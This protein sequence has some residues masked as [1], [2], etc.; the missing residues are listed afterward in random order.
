M[1]TAF[2]GKIFRSIQE[3][4]EKNKEDIEEIKYTKELLNLM[5]IRVVGEVADAADLP[6]PATYDGDFGDGFAVGT[7]T[8]YDYYIYTRAFDDNETPEWFNIGPFPI[9]G[10]EGPQGPRGPQGIQGPRGPQGFVGPRGVQGPQGEQGEQ[11]EEGP[12][13]PQGIAGTVV[14]IAG[15]IASTSLL[16]AFS[17]VNDFHLGYLVGTVVPYHLYVITGNPNDKDTW[18]WFDAGAFTSGGEY[19]RAVDENNSYLASLLVNTNGIGGN[20]NGVVCYQG[21]NGGIYADTYHAVTGV[22]VGSND[23]F[24]IGDDGYIYGSYLN[25]DYITDANNGDYYFDI[26]NG[27]VYAATIETEQIADYNANNVNP[28]GYPKYYYVGFAA[29]GSMSANQTVCLQIEIRLKNVNSLSYNQVLTLFNSISETSNDSVYQGF[30]YLLDSIGA[31]QDLTDI[32][33][34]CV[35]TICFVDTTPGA[36]ASFTSPAININHVYQSS[37]FIIKKVD[38]T[39]YGNTSWENFNG[40]NNGIE[41]YHDEWHN[42]SQVSLTYCRCTLDFSNDNGTDINESYLANTFFVRTSDDVEFG[43]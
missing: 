43:A 6:D 21:G 27:E 40:T 24:G 34:S 14:N 23:D 3:Q 29:T 18:A 38:S 15:Q 30:L 20:N 35:G 12:Q 10:P 36:Q 25:A 5:G 4:V 31:N 11:G 19:T 13:G 39:D 33:A 32:D 37:K 28:I 41:W 2:D 42:S 26:V 1:A 8:P 9:Q 17:S 22:W 16:P 7:E